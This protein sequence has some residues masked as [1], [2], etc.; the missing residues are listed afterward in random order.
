MAKRVIK[1]SP[2]LKQCTEALSERFPEL[3]QPTI[4]NAAKMAHF[5]VLQLHLDYLNRLGVVKFAKNKRESVQ[6]RKVAER[7][8]TA[9][10]KDEL[11]ALKENVESLIRNMDRMS[12]ECHVALHLSMTS[13]LEVISSVG[14]PARLPVADANKVTAAVEELDALLSAK[15]FLLQMLSAIDRTLTQFSMPAHKPKRDD[16]YRFL[17]P[18]ALVWLLCTQEIPNSSQKNG[19]FGVFCC[20]I[21]A[22]AIPRQFADRLRDEEAILLNVVRTAVRNKTLETALSNVVGDFRP[23]VP[24]SVTCR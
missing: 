22:L 6:S 20:K 12:P 5:A 24:A 21:L 8:R 13:K 15:P 9:T 3:D 18:L 7:I 16:L 19:G 2:F 23:E 1:P 17:K 11:N 14:V 4:A 10:I